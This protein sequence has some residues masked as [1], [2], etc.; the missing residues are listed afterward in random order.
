MAQSGT[1]FLA[2]LAAALAVAAFRRRKAQPNAAAKPMPQPQPQPEPQPQPQPPFQPPMAPPSSGNFVGAPGYSWPHKN[3][4]PNQ[5]AFQNWLLQHGY[6][7]S[8]SGNVRDTA[9]KAAVALL[10]QDWNTVKQFYYPNQSPGTLTVDTKLGPATI[11]TMLFI[12]GTVIPQHGGAQGS[13][14]PEELAALWPGIVATAS[15][16]GG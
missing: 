4:W 1:I 10:Q 12:E 11:G 5:L 6:P 14:S 13:L 9:T 7:A 16:S 8:Q 3:R 15:Q 2:G